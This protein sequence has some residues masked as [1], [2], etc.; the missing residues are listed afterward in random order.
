MSRR[1]RPGDTLKLSAVDFNRILEAADT[2][3][4]DRLTGGV[5]AV[6]LH[7]RDAATVRVHYLSGVTVPIGGAVG[8]SA[9]LGDPDDGPAELARFIR[10]TTVQAVQP[11]EL[12][13]RGRFGIA[14]EPIASDKTG[15]V[16]FAGLVVARV[17]MQEIWHTWADISLAGG[18]VLESKPDGAA[19]I[20]WRRNPSQAG[21]QWAVVRLGKQALTQYFVRAPSTGIPPRAG[22]LT[23]S[24]TCELFRLDRFGSFERVKDPVGQDVSIVARN[25]SLQRVRGPL[26]PSDLS[27][28]LAVNFDGNRCWT[29]TPPQQT[30]VCKPLRRIR[31]KAWGAHGNYGF[32]MVP[33]ER[34]ES[35]CRFT[36]SVTIRC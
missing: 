1:V 3:A 29:I 10:D 36:T 14:I 11:I 33:G 32:K 34:S 17:N 25:P 30:L 28:F 26:S 22:L 20:L 35:G 24:A 18:H 6:K 7:A 23:G 27:L 8:F 2:I 12:Q 15:R 21:E 16:V 19:E 9:P 5:G 4:R 31:P 13:H